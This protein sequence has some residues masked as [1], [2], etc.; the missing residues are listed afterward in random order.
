LITA[1][2]ETKQAIKLQMREICLQDDGKGNEKK[3]EATVKNGLTFKILLFTHKHIHMQIHLIVDEYLIS[4]K[5]QTS[6]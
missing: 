6:F 4:N 1:S 2:L 5:I 3:K